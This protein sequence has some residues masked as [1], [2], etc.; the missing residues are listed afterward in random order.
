M[1]NIQITTY[2]NNK[3][4]RTNF[5]ANAHRCSVLLLQTSVSQYLY[6]VYLFQY[7]PIHTQTIPPT[8]HNKM[9]KGLGW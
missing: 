2:S 9:D 6:P 3:T 5:V 4:L 1:K 7:R 8:L